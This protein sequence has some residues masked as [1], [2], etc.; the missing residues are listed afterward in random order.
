MWDNVAKFPELFRHKV[1]VVQYTRHTK[2]MDAVEMFVQKTFAMCAAGLGYGAQGVRMPKVKLS[3]HH[4]EED[5]HQWQDYAGQIVHDRK[6]SFSHEIDIGLKDIWWHDGRFQRYLYVMI[7]EMAHSKQITQRKLSLSS[8]YHD[9]KWEGKP[10]E[11]KDDDAYRTDEYENLPW[12]KDADE[13]AK[14]ALKSVMDYLRN[15]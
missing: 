8:P 13:S 1:K 14:E 5:E 12:E 15:G 11:V 6:R 3:I 7:H 4:A 9:A 10:H 2:A